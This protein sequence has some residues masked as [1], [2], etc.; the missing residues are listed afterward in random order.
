MRKTLSLQG[1]QRRPKTDNDLWR[2][3]EQRKAE[4]LRENKQLTAEEY[5]AGIR[6]IVRELGI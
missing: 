3:Y 4:F 1:R 6:K 5:Q 2:L